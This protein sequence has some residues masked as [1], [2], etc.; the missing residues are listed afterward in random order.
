MIGPAVSGEISKTGF[1]EKVAKCDIFWP[2]DQMQMSWEILTLGPALWDNCE[3]V[4][5]MMIIIIISITLSVIVCAWVVGGIWNPP[6]NICVSRS[7]FFWQRKIKNVHRVT[8]GNLQIN[9]T[10]M[11]KKKKKNENTQHELVKWDVGFGCIVFV[12][13]QMFKLY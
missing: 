9:M 4:N 7:Y 3:Y 8:I 10:P 6:A 1:S 13:L 2:E 11:R 12:F 5:L